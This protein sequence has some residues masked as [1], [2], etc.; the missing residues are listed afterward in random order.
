MTEFFLKLIFAFLIG[1]LGLYIR[2]AASSTR[3]S[4]F[5]MVPWLSAVCFC[6]SFLLALWAVAFTSLVYVPKEK[7]ATLNKVYGVG[8]LKPG[9]RLATNGENGLQAK[10]LTQGWHTGL[11]LTITHEI[12][13]H[14]VFVVP[15]RMCATLSA[16]DGQ[17]PVAPF[18][19]SWKPEEVAKM[20]NDAEYFLTTGHGVKGQQATVLTP[21]V[22]TLHPYLWE[23]ATLVP[24]VIIE[25]GTV[26]VVKSFISEPEV[27]F[28]TW[29]KTRNK[30]G[31]LSILTDAVIPKNGP[32][33]QIVPVGEVGVWEEPLSNGYYFI[34]PDCYFV[35][36]I[37]VT[38]MPF[39]YKGGYTARHANLDIGPKGEVAQTITS[40]TV[41][42]PKGAADSAITT[43]VQ[44][45]EVPVELRAL[46]QVTA[47]MAPYIVATLGISSDNVN[48]TS[49]IVE[50]RVLT[51]V[52]RTTLRNVVGGT[53]IN[54]STKE[55][56]L[57]KE[58]K[59]QMD[60]ATG[61]LMVNTKTVLR[62]PTLRDLA[63][64]REIIETKIE[65]TARK[66]AA[67]QGIEVTQVRIAETVLP[68][69]VTAAWKREEFAVQQTKA[70]AQEELTQKQ[71][72]AVEN[73]KATAEKQQVLVEAQMLASA[74]EQKKQARTTEAEGEKAMM[75]ALAEGQKAQA[76]VL[77]QEQTAQLQMF[78]T[79]I[80]ELS[81]LMKENPQLISE[82]LR[83]TS[84]FVPNIVV[85][86]NGSSSQ[87]GNLDAAAVLFGTMLN[88]DSIK[89]L[90]ASQN[91]AVV[92]PGAVTTTE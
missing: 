51:P 34:N 10:I 62:L 25:Q 26:G 87:S 92:K 24:G 33:A 32:K 49:E 78:N 58:G 91:S 69:E 38:E 23:K 60:K 19:P 85:N 20:A 37:P 43:R 66:E 76:S 2:K 12:E 46:V 48:Q 41:E 86:S 27:N 45:F 28:G 15:P 13:L 21:G 70:L 40:F 65:E 63:E 11:M 9:Q 88:P 72:Q 18:A 57:D 73:A 80:K 52:L 75:L 53:Y 7:F 36:K 64:N 55:L 74:A 50:S 17:P 68:A 83:S 14:D 59:P 54:A 56:V 67:D 82:G 89:K 30:D 71:R 16:K 4:A 31:K 90:E 6:C 3:N 77:G 44:G 1:V 8:Q 39:E 5:T 81:T 29:K 35:T 42:V 84:K 22:Y 61:E 47:K 79:V